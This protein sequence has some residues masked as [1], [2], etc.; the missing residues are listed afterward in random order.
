[1]EQKTLTKVTMSN[2]IKYYSSQDLSIMKD[3]FKN[4]P[5]ELIEL[6]DIRK[7]GS[8]HTVWINPEHISSMETFLSKSN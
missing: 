1:M 8:I 7:D 3:V 2:G 6:I 5:L 4:A